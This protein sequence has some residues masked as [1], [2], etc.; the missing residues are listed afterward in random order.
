MSRTDKEIELIRS[1]SQENKSLRSLQRIARVLESTIDSGDFVNE[2]SAAKAKA[3]LASINREII[4]AQARTRDNGVKATREVMHSKITDA[5]Y[6]INDPKFRQAKFYFGQGAFK[7]ANEEVDEIL[8]KLGESV[9]Q[10]KTVVSDSKK[11][12]EDDIRAR[13]KSE[14][15]AELRQKYNLA[16]QDTAKNG[17]ISADEQAVKDA[18]VKS[19]DNPEARAQYYELRKRK[20]W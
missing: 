2:G 16:K 17:G 9:D 13:I 10:T 12:S 7:E 3:E 19:P 4:Q 18:F 8:A 5:G 15:D 1:S 6:D 14:V 20:G 11:E